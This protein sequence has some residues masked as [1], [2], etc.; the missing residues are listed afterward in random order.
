[1]C[2]GDTTLEKAIIGKDGEVK[3][4]VEGWGVEHVCRDYST[5]YEFATANHAHNETGI[6]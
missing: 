1:M 6:S 4:D 2:A 5:I 3:R